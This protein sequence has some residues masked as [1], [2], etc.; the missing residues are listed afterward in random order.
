KMT[1]RFSPGF[2]DFDLSYQPTMLYLVKAEKNAGIG[3]T[4]RHLLVP[5]K[6]VS[7]VIGM[8]GER[9]EG[10]KVCCGKCGKQ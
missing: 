8:G 2:G 1:T 7:A 5:Q 6:S 3:L 4:D 10:G 9:V